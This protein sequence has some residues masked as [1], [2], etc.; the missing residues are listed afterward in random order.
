M[1]LRSAATK[2]HY[3]PMTQWF[4]YIIEC[5]DASYYVGIT[6]DLALRV[7][8][9]NDGA[10]ARWTAA[11]LPVELRYA[12]GHPTKSEARKREIEIK[13]WRRQKKV[14]LFH[15]PENLVLHDTHLTR[16][17]EQLGG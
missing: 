14:E 9:H 16:P 11:R 8:E 5:S 17:D 2:G 3:E 15:T 6:N 12:E 13:G 1:T 4:T 10:G 7:A